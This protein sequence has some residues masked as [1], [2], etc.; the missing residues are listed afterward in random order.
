MPRSSRRK[1]AKVGSLT[2]KLEQAWEWVREA[3]WSKLAAVVVAVGV[4]V[5][6]QLDFRSTQ[7]EQGKQLS[8]HGRRLTQIEKAIDTRFDRLDQRAD[9]LEAS[10]KDFNAGVA[11]AVARGIE[12]GN[13]KLIIRIDEL[14]ERVE[15]IEQSQG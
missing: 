1:A 3:T 2:V 4:V 8:N 9:D 14:M 15:A 12:R 13:R 7:V 10:E 6:G 11:R 5:W